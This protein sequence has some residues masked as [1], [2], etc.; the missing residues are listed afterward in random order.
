MR[1]RVGVCASVCERERLCVCVYVCANEKVVCVFYSTGWLSG[2]GCFNFIGLFPQKIPRISGSF[3]ERDPQLKASYVFSPT[4]TE[5]QRFIGCLQLHFSVSKRATNYR[6]LLRRMAYKS[7]GIARRWSSHSSDA[8]GSGPESQQFQS[9]GKGATRRTG[10][11]VSH[12]QQNME[13]RT[14]THIHTDT[15]THRHTHT[16]TRTHVHTY[17]HTH[18]RIHAH[19]HAYAHIHIHTHKCTHARTSAARAM[20]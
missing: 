20:P 18:T 13:A 2:T 16:H 5:W 6:A 12:L 15:Q 1:E 14:R 11:A 7:Y 19:T 8:G 4:S 10:G 3:A 17:T 9:K